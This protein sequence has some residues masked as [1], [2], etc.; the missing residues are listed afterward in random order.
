MASR[1][2]ESVG[3]R[4][5]RPFSSRV[6]SVYLEIVATEVANTFRSQ[7]PLQKCLVFF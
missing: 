5:S 7:F 4:F 2:R 1:E 6:L 3:K